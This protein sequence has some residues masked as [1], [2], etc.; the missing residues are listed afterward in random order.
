[1]K[2]SFASLVTSNPKNPTYI[3]PESAMMLGEDCLINRELDNCVMGEVKDFASINNMYVLLSNDGFQQVI[4]HGKIF[5]LRAKELF[6]WSPSFKAVKD[7][8]YC[9][10]NDVNNDDI[11]NSAA[12][13]NY[14][15]EVVESDDD[16]VSNT[17]FDDQE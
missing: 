16:Y 17:K 3:S 11:A 10:D 13:D 9:S 2:A 7:I 1:Q 5:V 8:K 12:E 6:A 4:V 14:E 15:A